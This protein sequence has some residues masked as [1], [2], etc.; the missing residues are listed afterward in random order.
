MNFITVLIFGTI[1]IIILVREVLYQ[2]SVSMKSAHLMKKKC[3]E[4]NFIIF[5]LLVIVAALRNPNTGADTAGYVWLYKQ[6][7]NGQNTIMDYWELFIHSIQNNTFKDSLFWDL[8]NSVLSLIVKNEQVWLALIS[9]LFLFT[10]YKIIK[11]YSKDAVISWTYILCVFIY[12][13]IM[14]GLRQSMAMVL[15]LISITYVFDRK[16]IGFCACIAAAYLFHNSSIVF[17]VIYPLRKLR[18]SKFYF[19]VIGGVAAIFTLMPS[20]GVL[21]LTKLVTASRFEEY[22]TRSGLYTSSGFIILL[23]I[24][25]FCYYIYYSC[26]KDDEHINILFTIS[27]VGLVTQAA[28]S[29]VAEMFRISYYFNMF[30]MLLVPNCIY[31]I[32]KGEIRRQ[33]AFFVI[34]AFLGYFWYSGAYNYWFFWQ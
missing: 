15:I 27:M 19:V 28:A 1:S 18:V 21:I 34:L 33:Y 23:L 9:L 11:K 17:L 8:F 29:S 10:A 2:N 25:I 26:N 13:F 24:F 30:N 32:Q 12:A 4:N 5:F 20:L 6:V 3:D 7:L 14:Q 31:L 22:I 16:P